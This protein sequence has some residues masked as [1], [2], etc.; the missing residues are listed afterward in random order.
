MTETHVLSKY[1]QLTVYSIYTLLV[2]SCFTQL[3]IHL[4][5]SHSE[6]NQLDASLCNVHIAHSANALGHQLSQLTNQFRA[7]T[8]V[9]FMLFWLHESPVI[10][11]SN[12]KS[13]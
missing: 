7:T 10:F 11:E 4:K 3:N 13:N 9:A 6:A 2:L 5:L 12:P 1:L 8:N